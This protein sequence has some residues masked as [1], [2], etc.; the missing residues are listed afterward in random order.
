[1]VCMVSPHYF[2]MFTALLE[3][4]KCNSQSS[5]FF[6]LEN[7]STF[8]HR[9]HPDH[10]QSYIWMNTKAGYSKLQEGY[11][12]MPSLCRY[13]LFLGFT[14][15]KLS[16]IAY[17]RGMYLRTE[18]IRFMSSLQGCSSLLMKVQR[19]IKKQTDIFTYNL[20]I[21]NLWCW[22]ISFKNIESVS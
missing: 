14:R 6:S 8:E 22:G 5:L 2:F 18:H 3:K 12:S 13:I 19:M 21:R 20:T 9:L 17:E 1:M 4:Y 16:V 10:D 15:R 7:S 11:Y